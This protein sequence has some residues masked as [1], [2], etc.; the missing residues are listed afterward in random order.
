MGEIQNPKSRPTSRR[1]RQR[2]DRAHIPVLPGATPGP[3]TN[4]PTAFEEPPG[5]CTWEPFKQGNIEGIRR[6][7]VKEPKVS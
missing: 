2:A 1:E 5:S 4:S 3:A 7:E 6:V